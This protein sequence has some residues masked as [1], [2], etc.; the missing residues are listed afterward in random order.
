[1]VHRLG[2]K[3][4]GPVDWDEAEPPT[5][6]EED[7]PSVLQITEEPARAG[8]LL[9]TDRRIHGF[10]P[11]SLAPAAGIEEGDTIVSLDGDRE[12]AKDAR[13]FVAALPKTAGATARIGVSRAG[14]EHE[15][16]LHMQPHFA[17]HRVWGSDAQQGVVDA[18]TGP[19]VAVACPPWALPVY[20]AK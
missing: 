18:P 15:V 19:A 11:G 12:V 10:T 1:M 17:C 7:G 9:G 3:P 16:S 5:D 20:A 8:L 13:A 2:T 14:E 6:V 4:Q